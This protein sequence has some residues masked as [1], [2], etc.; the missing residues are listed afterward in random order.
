MQEAQRSA[1]A[2]DDKMTPEVIEEIKLVLRKAGLTES[3]ISE[4]ITGIW[5]MVEVPPIQ[6]EDQYRAYEDRYQRMMRDAGFIGQKRSWEEYMDYIR[7][8]A[9]RLALAIFNRMA[10][11]EGDTGV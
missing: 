7:T 6:N 9:G 10:E 3:D 8:P 2:D 5:T 4:A 11:W 1:M